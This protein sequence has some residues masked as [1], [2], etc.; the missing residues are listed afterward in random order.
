MTIVDQ[1]ESIFRAAAKEV[2]TYQKIAIDSVLVITDRDADGAKAFG[3]H[4][5]NYAKVLGTD[6]DVRWRDVSG[7]EFNTA[8]ELI[9]LVEKEK[10]DLICTYRC[11]HSLS[12]KYPFSLGVHLDVLTQRTTVP[13]LVHP[14][15]DAGRAYDHALENTRVVMAVTDH[16]AGDHHLV[17]YAARFTENDGTLWLSHIEDQQ[18]FERYMDVI[19]KIP[20]IDTDE[21][22]EL[23]QKQLLKAPKEYA[24][25]CAAAMQGEDLSITVK[26]IV[27][28]GDQLADYKSLIAEHKVN[29]LVMN[30]KDHDQFAMHGMAYPLAIEVREIPILML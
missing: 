18:T 7:D 15:P 27:Q 19:S 5:R 3:E 12:W 28:L 9:E 24:T 21:A 17:N 26:S 23:L 29:L 4:V 25:S 2:F 10:P 1:F 8:G 11:L 6:D 16:L 14:H 22:R 13:V 20:Q 30:T